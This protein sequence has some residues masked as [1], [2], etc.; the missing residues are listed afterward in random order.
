MNRINIQDRSFVVKAVVK[1]D[2]ISD[3]LREQLKVKYNVKT[4]L[5]DNSNNLLF[6]D[7]IINANIISEVNNEV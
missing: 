2:N 7:E 1:D 4:V 5:K 6:V 3:E